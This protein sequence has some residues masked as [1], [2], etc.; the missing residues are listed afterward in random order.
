[1]GNWLLNLI[2]PM[3]NNRQR[4]ILDSGLAQLKDYQ[5]SHQIRNRQDMLNALQHFGVTKDFLSNTG[6]LAKNPVVQKIAN[7]CNIDI[8]KVQQDISSLMG[9]YSQGNVKNDSRAVF[10]PLKAYRDALD[11]LK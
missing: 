5:R 2:K 4:Q 6:G 1:M 10:D 7:V 8:D 11:K 9:T 3:L